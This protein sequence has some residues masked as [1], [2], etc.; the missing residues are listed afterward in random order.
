[1]AGLGLPRGGVGWGVLTPVSLR[2]L[3]EGPEEALGVLRHPCRTEAPGV[4][5]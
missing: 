1:M 4:T 2:Q 3:I 5:W